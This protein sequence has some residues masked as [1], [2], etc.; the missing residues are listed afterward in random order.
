L[1]SKAFVA[2]MPRTQANCAPSRDQSK[3]RIASVQIH[4]VVAR[5][6]DHIL[7][8]ATGPNGIGMLEKRMLAEAGLSKIVLSG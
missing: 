7:P 5:L 6:F 2:Q 4:T 3:L 1:I 8:L